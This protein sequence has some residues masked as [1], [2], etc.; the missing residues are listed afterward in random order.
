MGR[1]DS[2]PIA[3]GSVG[4]CEGKLHGWRKLR[5]LARGQGPLDSEMPQM[6]L[7]RARPTR[8]TPDFSRRPVVFN[9]NVGVGDVPIGFL[10]LSPPPVLGGW[11][12]G[13][14]RFRYFAPAKLSCLRLSEELEPSRSIL[15]PAIFLIS[16]SLFGS[17][18]LVHCI[19]QFSFLHV[20]VRRSIRGIFPV[21]ASQIL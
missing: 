19:S 6:P 9:V 8:G 3:A 20:W 7:P 21:V 2:Q 17:F 12:G 11:L 5:P 1:G 14:G 10:S 13:G 15:T 4:C 16:L 18:H